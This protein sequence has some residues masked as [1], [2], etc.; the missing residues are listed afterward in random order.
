[1]A[2]RPNSASRERT[3]QEIDDTE[4]RMG[5]MRE[6]DF[7][8]RDERRGRIG[9]A[10]PQAEVDAEF[11]PER[12]ARSGLS[13]GE[14]LADNDTEDHVTDDD[15]S[16]STLIHED[17]AETPAERGGARRPAD[18]VLSQVDE[19]EIGGGIGLDEAE[20]GRSAPLDGQPWTDRVSPTGDEEE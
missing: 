12:L 2:T 1:M 18:N 7:S 5:S 10:R 11:P 17:G 15:L 20:L 4:D 19:R 13:G 8:D 3:P 14:A 6:L 16:P 9:D